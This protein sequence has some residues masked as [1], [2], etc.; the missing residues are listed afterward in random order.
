MKDTTPNSDTIKDICFTVAA[1]VPCN[2][3]IQIIINILCEKQRK[4]GVENDVPDMRREGDR[5]GIFE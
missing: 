3:P 2:N 5:R 4:K 1:I